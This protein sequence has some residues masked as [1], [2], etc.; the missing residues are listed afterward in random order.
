LLPVRT[1]IYQASLGIEASRA[2][3]SL[4][5]LLGKQEITAEL[6]RTYARERNLLN[7]IFWSDEKQSFAFA[8]DPDNHRVD[9]ATVLPAVPM[10]FGL[11][12]PIKARE[13][14]AHLAAP[15]MQ[16]D[17]GMRILSSSSPKYAS[18]GYHFGSVWPLFT[19]WASV[20]EY[21][22]HRELAAY[23]NLR[24]NA[25]LA[26]D[27]SLGHVTEVLAGDYYKPLSTSTPQQV[28]SAAMIV[29]PL[30]RGLF[31][32]ETNA[33]TDE[34]ALTPHVPADWPSFT[35]GNLCVGSAL[36][37]LRYHNDAKELRLEI[38]RVGSC[39]CKLVFSPA[40]S[41]RAEVRAATWNGRPI[42]FRLESSDIDQHVSVNFVVPAG[43]STL[44]MRIDSD[45]GLSIAPR[46]PPLGSA[47]QGLR[48]L[49]ESW[50]PEGDR[51]DL[52][53][54]GLPARD[55]ELS[56]SNAAQIAS[57]QG[58][59]LHKADI[60]GAKLVVRFPAGPEA[61]MRRRITLLFIPKRNVPH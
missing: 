54:A 28:W 26:L 34:V 47:S 14:I 13:T 61:Y 46:L 44:R 4:A 42:P 43:K 7:E 29:N 59:E 49:S 48:V 2:F 18:D 17:W 30:L 40:L 53:V 19:G 24:Q 60:G 27:G 38:N 51:L 3:S 20:G 25:L 8:I 36:L 35:I 32:I 11:L 6:D 23:L 5:R 50:T 31:G 22:Y 21:R 15:D 37:T 41:P 45:F 58:A 56:V 10:W 12:D 1:E 16:T 9:E 57:A 39:Q 52:E 33:T 55:Y